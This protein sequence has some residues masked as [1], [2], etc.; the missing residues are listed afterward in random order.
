MPASKK[1]TLDYEASFLRLE[2][3]ARLLEQGN[4]PL[5]QAMLLFNESTALAAR[6]NKTLTEAEQLLT[7]T[8]L[9]QPPEE[10]VSS[11]A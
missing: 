10:E 7:V 11:N 8:A 1:K 6:L 3:I 4:L 5:E 2:E 9:D